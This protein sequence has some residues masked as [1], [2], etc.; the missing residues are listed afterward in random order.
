MAE[1]R[2]HSLRLTSI[3]HL[4]GLCPKYPQPPPSL[5]KKKLVFRRKI[6]VESVK[7]KFVTLQHPSILDCAVNFE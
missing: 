5:P 1:C 2:R 3:F 6:E 7:Y 4:I